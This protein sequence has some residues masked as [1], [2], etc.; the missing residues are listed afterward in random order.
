MIVDGVM[1]QKTQK[2]TQF[3]VVVLNQNVVLLI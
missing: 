2:T 3:K 1:H